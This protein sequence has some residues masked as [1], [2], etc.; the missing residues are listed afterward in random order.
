M[1]NDTFGS[2]SV[3]KAGSEVEQFLGVADGG[4]L[5]P[6][7]PPGRFASS[8]PSFRS[9]SGGAQNSDATGFLILMLRVTGAM[10]CV[11]GVIA[12]FFLL[13]K[14]SEPGMLSKG[15]IA[16][17]QFL[18][19]FGLAFYH[20][21]AALL[22]FGCAQCLAVLISDADA[23]TICEAAKTG[24]VEVRNGLSPSISPLR[25]A[26]GAVPV[27]TTGLTIDEVV[28]KIMDLA[29]EGSQGQTTK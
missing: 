8:S 21:V 1:S 26:P 22:C 13:S 25:Q 29:R 15:E 12:F 6:S 16:P 18:T 2:E 14:F 24:S 23:T 10:L 3:T 17:W 27:D 20:V 9:G 28:A 5:P 11:I 19:A 7:W 4:N